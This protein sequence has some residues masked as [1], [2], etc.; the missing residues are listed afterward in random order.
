MERDISENKEFY[1]SIAEVEVNNETMSEE[2]TRTEKYGR[3]EAMKDLTESGYAVTRTEKSDGA[4]FTVYVQENQTAG[5]ELK[6]ILSR[7]G[8]LPTYPS[9][10]NGDDFVFSVK[11][12][13]AKWHDL[14]LRNCPDRDE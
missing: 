14:A 10:Y 4:V 1:N 8:Y 12:E 6:H 9:P 5:G 3:I 7:N 13:P 11:C 2:Q